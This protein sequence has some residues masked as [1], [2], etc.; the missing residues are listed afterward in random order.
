MWDLK[1]KHFK[2]FYFFTNKDTKLILIEMQP[3]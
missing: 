2:Y 3:K 1:E